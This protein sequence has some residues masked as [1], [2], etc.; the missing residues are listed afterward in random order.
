M[1]VFSP[2][3]LASGAEGLVATWAWAKPGAGRGN[4]LRSTLPSA[5]KLVEGSELLGSFCAVWART[6]AQASTKIARPIVAAITAL[7]RPS[8]TIAPCNYCNTQGSTQHPFCADDSLKLDGCTEVRSC[9]KIVL[10]RERFCM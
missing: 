7:Q 4:E 9:E 6:T 10:N 5:E 2:T 3:A 8:S 1:Q